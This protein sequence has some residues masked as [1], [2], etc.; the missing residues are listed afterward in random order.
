MRDNG[1]RAYFEE[2]N[3]RFNKLEEKY[4]QLRINLMEYGIFDFQPFIDNSHP[5]S[6][7]K[8]KYF[9]LLLDYLGLEIKKQG[10]QIVKK[11]RK[12]NSER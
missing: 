11:T 10:E 7:V 3:S 9:S 2:L 12:E 1:L 6:P 4:E 5:F 8:N